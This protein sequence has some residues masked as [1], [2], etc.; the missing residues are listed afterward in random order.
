MQYPHLD[1]L[2]GDSWK[3]VLADRCGQWEMSD[4]QKLQLVKG[5]TEDSSKELSSPRGF[6]QPFTD[7]ADREWPSVA[8]LLHF[9]NKTTCTVSIIAPNFLLTSFSCMV[10]K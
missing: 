4:A 6:L 7:D 10:R 5:E 3:F 1:K 8:Y 9:R 2:P